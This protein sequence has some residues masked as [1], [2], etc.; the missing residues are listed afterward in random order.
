MDSIFEDVCKGMVLSDLDVQIL[1][2]KSVPAVL[3]EQD[4]GI[5]KLGQKYIDFQIDLCS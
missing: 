1:P 3:K 5:K 2:K 4:N